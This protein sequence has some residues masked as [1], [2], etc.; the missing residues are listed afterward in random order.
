[1][2]ISEAQ[3]E[4]R[5]IFQGGFAG[6][7]VTSLIWFASA[8]AATWF[9]RRLGVEILLIACTFIFPLTQLFLRLTGRPVVFPKGN[10]LN[11]LAM[12]TAFIVPLCL[13]VV[14][15]ATTAR[16][17]WF[18]PAIMIVVGAHYLPFITL[19]GMPQFGVLG[20][21]LIA[22]GVFL[23]MRV[24]NNFAAGGW[25]TAVLLLI[26]AFLGRRAAASSPPSERL[27]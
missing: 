8:A 14:F 20:G 15:A 27:N 22:I 6:Q 7:F 12:Q 19:Y 18:Y 11:G 24:P 5:T 13:P 9:S 2:Q 16:H 3:E 23:G 21:L 25:I 26:F 10:P 1:M 17:A 4:V